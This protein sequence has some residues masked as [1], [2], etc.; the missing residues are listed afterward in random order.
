MSVLD[1]RLRTESRAVSAS[2][3]RRLLGLGF[4]LP[5]FLILFAAI[6]PQLERPA[7]EIL[8]WILAR[9]PTSPIDHDTLF[10][11]AFVV[12]SFLA[13]ALIAAVTS[14]TATLI[15]G[16]SDHH[17]LFW[18]CFCGTL[19]IVALLWQQAGG[20]AE[21]AKE[22]FPLALGSLLGIGQGFVRG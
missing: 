11:F 14:K 10:Y 20:H 18:L 12:L 9:G 5:L 1:D 3:P 22:L 7:G 2:Q 15:G 6:A 19:A 13:G 21:A 4:S 16:S 17:T 8:R